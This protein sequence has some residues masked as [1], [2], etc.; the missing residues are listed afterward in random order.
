MKKKLDVGFKI[1]RVGEDATTLYNNG[2]VLKVFGLAKAGAFATIET[3][4]GEVYVV[5]RLEKFKE[6]LNN[7]N[8]KQNT[9]LEIINVS[10]E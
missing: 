2:S 6:L 10:G 9:K 1:D 4:E 3:V 5:S 8:E 7:V